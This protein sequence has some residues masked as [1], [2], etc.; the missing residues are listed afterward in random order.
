MKLN[1]WYIRPFGEAVMVKH[2]MKKRRDASGFTLIELLVVIAIIALL[3][4]IL[5]PSLNKAKELARQA[6]CMSNLRGLVLT[7]LLYAQD[8]DD[9]ST[10]LVSG[11]TDPDL[12]VWTGDLW[13]VMLMKG[14]YS[15][16]PSGGGNSNFNCPSWAPNVY[17]DAD[18][19][20]TYYTYYTYGM[21]RNYCQTPFRL[22][23]GSVTSPESIHTGVDFGA[24]SEFLFLGDTS[25][26]DPVY[27]GDARK[28]FC[29][30]NTHESFSWSP[31]VHL[32]HARTGDFA[33]GD[34]HVEKLGVDDLLGNY[35]IINYNP[36]VSG[37]A[38]GFDFIE[39][40]IVVE[41]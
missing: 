31:T 15:D 33:F 38:T 40:A 8:N 39:S 2:S 6:V 35:G 27:Y 20:G 24:P 3:V 37:G 32:R 12:S 16:E 34:G 29:Y 9:W 22:L 10:P 23:S 13:S 36:S 18:T 17:P 1:L 26:Y 11:F 4:S 14:G 19:H 28:Q 5:L 21:R 7:Q 25:Y 41:E 30:F